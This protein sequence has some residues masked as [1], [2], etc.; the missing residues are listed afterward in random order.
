MEECVAKFGIIMLIKQTM[1]SGAYRIRH[2]PNLTE[3][4]ENGMQEKK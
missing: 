3:E 1:M 4:P 2:K